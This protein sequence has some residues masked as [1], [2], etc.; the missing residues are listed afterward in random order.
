[1][2][3]GRASLMYE[4]Y[5]TFPGLM[6]ASNSFGKLY[7]LGM[8]PLEGKSV[9]D[10]GCNEGFFC[11]AAYFAGARLVVGVDLR[12]EAIE[13]AR[14]RFPNV[15]FFLQSWDEEIEGQFDVVLLASAI[16]YADDQISLIH[17]LMAK[18]NQDG[19]LIVELGLL[20]GISE[21]KRDIKRPAGDTRTY[22]TLRYL[23]EAL[24]EY[25]IRLIGDSVN[26]SGD[27]VGRK[28]IH[29]RHRKPIVILFDGE[30]YS[31]KSTTVRALCGFQARSQNAIGRFNIDEIIV[32]LRDEDSIPFSAFKS[33]AKKNEYCTAKTST[34]M[35]NDG[36]Y[37]QFVDTIVAQ[38]KKEYP[39]YAWEGWVPNEGKQIVID[40]F[41]D[42]GFVVWTANPI[43]KPQL[44]FEDFRNLQFGMHETHGFETRIQTRS[45]LDMITIE[46]D[47]IL[48]HGW[49][50]EVDE[51]KPVTQFMLIRHNTQTSIVVHNADRLDVNKEFNIDDNVKLGFVIA[52]KKEEFFQGV[53]LNEILNG[54]FF[55]RREI[56]CMVRLFGSAS[57]GG[58]FLIEPPQ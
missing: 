11:G 5:Q 39:I 22:F 53:I 57:D 46:D 56:S 30:S 40:A 14:S 36:V 19:V 8:P 24:T 23:E 26:Q 55:E 58:M 34:S 13:R 38:R 12:E 54:I 17:R 9:L 2:K 3:L 28:V 15:K 33:Y 6:G 20:E 51:K 16:H 18:V 47:N 21:I 27:P 52:V 37:R 45:C 31:G 41:Q 25:V 7:C 44:D 48:F 10:V 4:Q 49:A 43:K 1:M 32:S 35:I 50:I 29:I 42:G